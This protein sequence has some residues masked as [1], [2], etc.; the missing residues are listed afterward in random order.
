MNPS[1]KSFPKTLTDDQLIAVERLRARFA[2]LPDERMPGRI[3]HRI[4]E[5]VMI[6]LCSILSDN[7][8]FT[9]M[10]TFA[11]SQLDWLRTFLPMEKGAP[12]HDV[13]RN[14]FIALR[15]ESLLTIL[16]D[17]CGGLDGKQIAIDGKAL[18]GSDSL[19]A[20]KKMV[21]VLRAWVGE[22]GISAV[23]ELCAEKS[24][25]L[26]ELPRLLDALALKG[27]TVTIDAMACHPHIAEQIHG[28]GGDYVIALKGNQKGTLETV[29][30]HFAQTDEQADALAAHQGVETVELSHGRFEKRVC[31]ITS[32]LEWFHKSWKWHGL[33]TVVRI[34]RTT[35]RTGTREE[36]SKETHYY[37]SSLADD[38]AHPADLVRSH[39]SVENTCHYV[40][41]VTFGEDDCQ[42]RERNAAHNLCVLRELSAKVLRDHPEKKSMRAKRKLAALDPAFRF[43]LLS[44]IPLVSHA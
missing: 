32:D 40:L 16:S 14:V 9:D 27:A 41:D 18:R 17:W 43:S 24:N 7:D 12:S 29:A 35:H 8:A 1:S 21:H 28:A 19:A 36:L 34:V 44:I 23:H 22:A 4:D 33:Q 15:P 13:F 20:G 37:L 11:R 39:W 25:E 31:T 42:V 38:A 6:A 3:I 30:G 5:V 26:E 2:Q 10:E